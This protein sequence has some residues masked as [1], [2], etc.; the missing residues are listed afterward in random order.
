MEL[1]GVIVEVGREVKR[2]KEGD[3]VFATPGFKFGTYAEYICLPE[4][5]MVAHKPANLG[6]GEAAA[7]PGG[8]ITALMCLKK[9][10][11]QKGQKV[12]V[13]GASGSVGTY[14]VQLAKY[15]G[16]EVTGV[17]STVNLELVKSLG[18]DRVVDYT[19]ENIT[20]SGETYDVVFD[21]VDKLPRSKGKKLLKKGGKYL[22]VSRDSGGERD[23]KQ[24]DLVF[25]KEQIEAGKL[26]PV[27]DRTYPFEEIVEAHR[28]VDRGHKKGNVVIVVR[29]SN[30]KRSTGGDA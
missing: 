8:G 18:A 30:E 16:A 5:D 1:S 12:L 13:Y 2:F 17:C 25:L 22:N 10:D 21:A 11:I 23:M 24:D 4:T 6:F 28:Y 26:K 3:T 29:K 7:V 14:A 27:I 19:K 15:H 9:A 20:E